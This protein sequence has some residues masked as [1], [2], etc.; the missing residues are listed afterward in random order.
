VKVQHANVRP[1]LTDDFSS[2][3]IVVSAICWLGGISCP[4]CPVAP[5]P[6]RH[7]ILVRQEA[8]NAAHGLSAKCPLPWVQLAQ[9]CTVALNR[10]MPNLLTDHLCAEPEWG[11]IR[12]LMR[13][14]ATESRK[15]LDFRLEAQVCEGFRGAAAALVTKRV[16]CRIRTW[17]KRSLHAAA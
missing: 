2:L 3:S 10:L 16:R 13:E 11:F 5:T 14:Y 15:E 8:C 17:P 7:T 4:P 9:A 6:L 1:L 12:V